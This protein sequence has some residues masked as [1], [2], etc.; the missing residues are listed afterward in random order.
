MNL[1]RQEIDL[2]NRHSKG[3]LRISLLNPVLGFG[4]KL[5][6]KLFSQISLNNSKW[7]KRKRNLP[8]EPISPS[9]KSISLDYIL[10]SNELLSASSKNLSESSNI[11]FTHIHPYGYEKMYP[12]QSKSLYSFVP[13]IDS[14]NQFIIGIDKIFAG[15]ELNIYF[16]LEEIKSKYNINDNYYIQWFYL[17]SNIWKPIVDK[18]ILSDTTNNLIQSGIVKFI[19]PIDINNKN[20]IFNDDLYYLK[21]TIKNVQ[22]FKKKLKNIFIN[23]VLIERI[24]SD[25]NYN[26]IFSLPEKSIDKPFINQPEID[27]V[28]QPYRNFNGRQKENEDNF[29]VRISEMLRTKNR[30]I[31]VRD[32][33][34]AIL[35]NFSNIS[36]VECLGNGFQDSINKNIDLIITLIPK[37]TRIETYDVDNFPIIDTELLFQVKKY[38]QNLISDD[39]QL[40]ISNPIYEKVKVICEVSFKEVRG[41]QDIK[42]FTN[43][44]NQDIIEFIAPWIK[45]GSEDEIIID[46]MINTDELIDYIKNKPYIDTVFQLSIIHIYPVY[47]DNEAEPIYRLFDTAVTNART[48]KTSLINS[49]FLP[50]NNHQIVV[51]DLNKKSRQNKLVGINELEIGKELIIQENAIFNESVIENQNFQQKSNKFTLTLKL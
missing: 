1:R 32:I 24:F 31:T 44:L 48:I 6:S 47:N 23:G 28:L 11:I 30:F 42:I 7:F 51:H 14:D 29:Y 10:E 21:V 39:I 26:E 46:N 12:N 9:L 19:T 17:A 18:N 4:H 13:I 50:V 45:F 25:S 40:T 2:I 33:T 49:I 35:K 16:E 37:F 27:T 5:F 43:L 8:N 3:I 41:T 15:Q 22:N 34:Q 20:T 36:L 38:V